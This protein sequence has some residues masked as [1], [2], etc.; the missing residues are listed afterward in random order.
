MLFSFVKMLNAEYIYFK[1]LWIW[2]DVRKFAMHILLCVNKNQEYNYIRFIY[3]VFILV[4]AIL[5]L[6]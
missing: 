3:C 6:I 4:N 5:I 2:I 1:P